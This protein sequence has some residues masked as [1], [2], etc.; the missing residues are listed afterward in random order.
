[1]REHDWGIAVD[2]AKLH[3]D[4]LVWDMVLPLQASAGNDI[5]LLREAHSAGFD[6]VSL[7]IAGDDCGIAEAIRLLA[8][9]RRRIREAGEEFVLVSSV[10]DI[11]RAKSCG[12]LAVGLHLEGTRCLE[13]DLAM[14]EVYYALGIRHNL[15]AFNLQNSA[16]G[17]CADEADVGLTRFGRRVIEEMNRVGMVV[18]LSHVGYRTSMDILDRSTA[19]CIISHSN[20][21]GIWPHYRNVKDDQIRRCAA[22][23]GVV[24][25]SG[26]SAY[27]GVE[28]PTAADVFRHIDYVTN[29]V[30]PDYVGLGLDFVRDPKALDRYVAANPDMWPPFGGRNFSDLNFF[31]PAKVPQLTEHLL[32][33]GYSE[34]DVRK[35]LGGNFLRAMKQVWK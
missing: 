4:A 14:I 12:F 5:S 10:E 21:Y 24:G 9:A 7:T 15:I 27:L 31:P 29:L 20:P 18:D 2:A 17:G 33:H 28:K 1:M 35:I 25:I 23:R 19:P 30:G 3:Y 11:L 22:S 34:A 16:G 13:R 6:F 8:D 26:S 32:E